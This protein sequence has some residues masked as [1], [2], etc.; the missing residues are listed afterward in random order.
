MLDPRLNMERLG[1]RPPGA[2]PIEALLD[3]RSDPGEG[4]ALGR[5]G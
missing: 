2:Y 1:A 3:G 5:A 4:P